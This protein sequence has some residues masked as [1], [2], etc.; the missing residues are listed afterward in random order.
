MTTATCHH[1]AFGLGVGW[2]M[3]SELA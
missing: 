2:L 3:A 1:F